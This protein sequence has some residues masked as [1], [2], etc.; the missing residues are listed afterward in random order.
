M[1]TTEGTSGADSLLKERTFTWLTFSIWS[2]VT[3]AATAAQ[4]IK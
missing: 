3:E 1:R 4:T 2:A